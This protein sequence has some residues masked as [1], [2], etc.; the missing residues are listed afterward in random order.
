VASNKRNTA[1]TERLALV[2]RIAKAVGCD[3]YSDSVQIISEYGQQLSRK[4]CERIVT[5][6]DLALRR[7]SAKSSE[8]DR[9]ALVKCLVALLPHSDSHIRGCL[10][11]ERYD[12]EVQFTLL[13]YL[14]DVRTLPE[15]RSLARDLPAI[16][17]QYI[18]DAKSDAAHAVWMA[19]DLLGDHWPIRS[20]I[21]PLIEASLKGYHVAGRRAALHGLAHA[22][23]R[24]RAKD[25]QR[26]E[27]CLNRVAK[28]D[29]SKVVRNEARNILNGSD[30]C[31]GLVDW[32]SS[33]ASEARGQAHRNAHHRD[34]DESR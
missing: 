4:H 12:E 24:A 31:A 23:T 11:R 29:R 26:I 3:L 27:A 18:A 33:V 16:I 19:G 7:R 34:F 20:G 17:G 8:R 30:P 25:R 5:R 15:A 14:D 21:A 28:A 32:R 10:L 1:R 13:C 6:L 2:Q 9:I 22:I